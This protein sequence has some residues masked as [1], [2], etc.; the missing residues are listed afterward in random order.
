MSLPLRY[1]LPNPPSP[2]LGRDAETAWLAEALQRR[3]VACVSAPGG[4]GK[5]ALVLHTL[6]RK[7]ARQLDR[8]VFVRLGPDLAPDELRQ[9]ALRALAAAAGIE[10]IDWGALQGDADALT[11]AVLDLAESPPGGGGAL[12]VVL[13]D[14]HHA[15]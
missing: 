7:H 9:E 1:R 10:T 3:P 12:W 13:D 2:F 8:I 5:T 6:H 15:P 4:L 11:T 14:L